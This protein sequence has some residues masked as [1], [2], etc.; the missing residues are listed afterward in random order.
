M[1]FKSS[2]RYVVI[3]IHFD[4]RYFKAFKMLGQLRLKEDGIKR[5][6]D[7][8]KS[9][10]EERIL[11]STV[12]CVFFYSNRLLIKSIAINLKLIFRR[13]EY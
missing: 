6:V 12:W 13:E 4:N 9:K 7:S 3:Y 2:E 5:V 11:S 10:I 1:N 8:A